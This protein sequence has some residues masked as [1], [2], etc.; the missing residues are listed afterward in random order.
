MKL[1]Q[2]RT[3]DL[4]SYEDTLRRLLKGDFA[5]LPPGERKA[6]VEQIIKTSAVAAMAMGAVPVPLLEMPVMAAMVRA[7]GKV[8]GVNTIGKKAMLEIAAA[9]G[10]GLVL[11]QAMRLIPFVGAMAGASRVYGTTWAVGRVAEVYFSRAQ[12]VSGEEMRRVFEETMEAKR[13]EQGQ[14]GENLEERLRTLE[15]LY[16]KQL[17]SEQEYRRKKQDLLDS[18]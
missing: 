6:K 17:I 11:R 16:I 9:M 18:I 8:Y 1:L 4:K 13:H 15:N 12:S 7:I 3:V 2:N 10:G 14:G 5:D